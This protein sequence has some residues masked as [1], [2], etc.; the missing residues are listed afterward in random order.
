MWQDLHFLSPLWLL[1]LLPLGLLFL[2]LLR[3]DSAGNAWRHV[4]DPRL[5]ALLTVGGPSGTGHRLVL[6][7]L[8]AGWIIAV[9]ALANPTFERAPVPA[10]RADAARVV[11]LDLSRS[12]LADDLTPSRLERAR[13]KLADILR[14][15]EAGQVGLVAF[16]G[17][18]FAVSPLTDDADTILGM[19]DALSPDVMPVQGSR[20]DL[21]IERAAEL[22]QQAGAHHGEVVLLTDDA[23]DR[24]ARAAAGALRADGHRLAVIGVGT[25]EGAAVPGVR[26]SAGPVIARLDPEALR[27]LAR[28]GGGVYATLSTGD[29][30]LRRALRDPS[31]SARV[32]EPEDP[33]LTESWKELGPWLSLLLLPLGALAFRRGWVAGLVL[34]V[35]N[36]SLMAPQPATAGGWA[37]LWLRPEQQAQRALRD[38][39]YRRALELASDPGRIG[40]ARYRLG[41]YEGAAD[42]FAAGDDADL[43]YNRGN[44]LAAAGEL[45]AAVAA[46]DEAL[47]RRPGMPDALHNKEQI[48]GLLEQR[49]QEATEQADPGEPG[50][51]QGEGQTAPEPESQSST[52]DASNG[53]QDG[54]DRAQA[55]QTQNGE[56]QSEQ[57]EA[58]RTPASP[59]GS[60]SQQEAQAAESRGAPEE[61]RAQD[62][63]GDRTDGV[64]ANDETGSDEPIEEVSDAE[65]AAEDYREEAR[66]GA[67][68]TQ[69]QAEPRDAPDD[70]GPQPGPDAS[71]SAGLTAE[72]LESRQAADQWL[73]R[74]PDDPAG[75]LRRKFLY[76][77]RARAAEEDELSAGEPW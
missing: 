66:A 54:A 9:V 40:T 28:A 47:S 65:Q 18:A 36:L 68:P 76:Q 59:D 52:T 49:E 23:G 64:G 57:A 7:L 11:A 45:E 8:A 77:Y 27:S 20:L 3:G 2:A 74:I 62:L 37:D 58:G 39:D 42:A 31:G 50:D 73:R 53:E 13:Y 61:R 12:M 15:S 34:V 67:G 4:V 19:L 26:T 60:E 1:A 38:R 6:S 55:P 14:R 21:A 35:A 5:L 43:H 29:A 44:A 30:D 75:L 51:Q 72:E 70:G 33:R 69:G 24:R 46:Y 25:T 32:L 17:D 16:A 63:G 71:V 41:D 48:E 22:L 10:F 56:A